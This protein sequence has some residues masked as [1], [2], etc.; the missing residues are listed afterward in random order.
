MVS[1]DAAF[2]SAPSIY[3]AEVLPIALR[4]KVMGLTSAVSYAIIA[5]L[6]EAAPMA[7]YTIRHNCELSLA[8]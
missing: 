7:F 3:Q 2:G 1:I 4:S 6:S 5:G 8:A